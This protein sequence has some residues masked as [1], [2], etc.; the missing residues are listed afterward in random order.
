MT[1]LLLSRITMYHGVYVRSWLVVAVR[2]TT[3][4]AV[5]L[6]ALAAS[7]T[8]SAAEVQVTVTGEEMAWGEAPVLVPMTAVYVTDVAVLLVTGTAH[9]VPFPQDHMT[10][11]LPFRITMYHDVGVMFRL[12]VAVSVTAVPGVTIV[13]PAAS[14]TESAVA[15]QVTVT[16]P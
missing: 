2:V 3:V 13:A 10:V 5:T 7:V 16:G 11:L 14:V 15:L 6:V 8:E 9:V 1:L 12:A 4:P